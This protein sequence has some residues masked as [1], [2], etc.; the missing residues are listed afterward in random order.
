MNVMQRIIYAGFAAAALASASM[1]VF[2][3]PEAGAFA[4]EMAVS[5]SATDSNRR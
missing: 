4:D 3:S 1:P 5:S 2:S